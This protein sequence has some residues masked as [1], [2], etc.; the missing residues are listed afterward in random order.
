MMVLGVTTRYSEQCWNLLI[1]WMDLIL[2]ETSRFSWQQIG[3]RQILYTV[4]FQG[5]SS[6]SLFFK[7]TKMLK[8]VCYSS[9]DQT[10]LIQL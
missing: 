5:G 3:K 1:S 9:P 10:P 2:E 7:V 4:L 8:I 6:S